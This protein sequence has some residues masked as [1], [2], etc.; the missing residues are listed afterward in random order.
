MDS[1][2]RKTTVAGNIPGRAV[3]FLNSNKSEENL[4]K[5]IREIRKECHSF[6]I[7][8]QQECVVNKGPDRDID[9]VAI[10]VLITLL[11]AHN[12]KVV[13]V[14]HMTDITEDF[15]DLNEFM[16]DVAEIGV[17]FFELAS[18][19]FQYHHYVEDSSREECPIWDGGAG[20]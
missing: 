18:K 3:L 13:L 14:D 20:C 9:R 7:D 8:L 2:Q 19:H 11:I 12:Y 15:L 16:R 5:L 10:N 4:K 17:C 6:G 1:M